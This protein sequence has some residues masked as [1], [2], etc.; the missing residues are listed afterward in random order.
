MDTV[1]LPDVTRLPSGLDWGARLRELRAE[2]EAALRKPVA[3][4]DL[5]EGVLSC[6]SD[7][8]LADLA[9]EMV[10]ERRREY[11]E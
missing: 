10:G 5:W 2:R 8:T 6:A 3:E 9:T 7:E 4:R 11:G 1:T